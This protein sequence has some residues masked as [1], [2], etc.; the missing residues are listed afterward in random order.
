[1]S[2][3]NNFLAYPLEQI[4]FVLL[5]LLIA[6]TFHEFAHAYTAYRFGDPTPKRM[7]RV[8]LNPRVHLDVLGTLLIFIAGFG[9]AKPVLINRG[10]FKRPRLMGIVVAAAGPAANL[11]IAFAGMLVYYALIYFQ[12]VDQASVGVRNAV[13]LFMNILIGLNLILFIFNLI[14]LPPLDGYH[15]LENLLPRSWAVKLQGLQQWAIF[16]FLLVVFIPPVY[17]VTLMPLF[18]LSGYILSLF[19]LVLGSLFD[20]R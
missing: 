7:G 20:L 6:F 4:P 19:H 16:L 10:H 1:V 3:L 17:R 11:L 13:D 9:W 15:I 5:V 12:V 8:T 18:G 14:P 2:G